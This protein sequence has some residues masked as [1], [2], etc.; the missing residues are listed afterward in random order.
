MS[1]AVP[2]SVQ[3]SL[4]VRGVLIAIALCFLGLMLILPM[5]LVLTQALGHGFTLYLDALR[6]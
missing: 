3:D 6:D 5:A 1:K 2:A 4:L